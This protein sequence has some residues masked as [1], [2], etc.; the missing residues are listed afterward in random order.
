[1]TPDTTVSEPRI[2][3]ILPNGGQDEA[4]ELRRLREENARLR[5]QLGRQTASETVA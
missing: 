2:R 4:E 5:E 1:V 3:Q